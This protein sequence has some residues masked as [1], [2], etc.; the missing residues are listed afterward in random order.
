LQQ[1]NELSQQAVKKAEDALKA[2]QGT[3]EQLCKGVRDAELQRNSMEDALL[4]RRMQLQALQNSVGEIAAAC[5][6]EEDM[7][8]DLELKDA[9]AAGGSVQVL[10]FPRRCVS[11]P[12]YNGHLDLQAEAQLLLSSRRIRPLNQLGANA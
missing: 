3:Y 10:A 12:K 8:R 5:R 2:S 1:S 7:L 6:R 9:A 11:F 4:D